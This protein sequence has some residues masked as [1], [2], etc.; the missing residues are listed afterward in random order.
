MSQDR[1]STVPGL[2]AALSPWALGATCP[3]LSYLGE[4]LRHCTED[5]LIAHLGVVGGPIEL[6]TRLV[7]TGLCEV[8]ISHH[9]YTLLNTMADPFWD[10]GRRAG[11]AAVNAAP[12]AVASWCDGGRG[13]RAGAGTTAGKDPRASRRA[14]LGDN[15][16]FQQ[17]QVAVPIIKLFVKC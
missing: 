1:D 7:E 5:D 11:V 9:R 15:P 14:A 8:A 6:M 17:P 16:R 3:T 12:L 10:A 4:T 2:P 13:G